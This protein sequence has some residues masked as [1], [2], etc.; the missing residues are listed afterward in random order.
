MKHRC[1][2]RVQRIPLTA[3]WSEAVNICLR[4]VTERSAMNCNV[5]NYL[6]H[7]ITKRLARQ[8][9]LVRPTSFPFY[10]IFILFDLAAHLLAKA[11]EGRET[12]G[13]CLSTAK[14]SND[15]TEI[16]ARSVGNCSKCWAPIAK[17]DLPR[18]HC[19]YSTREST[20]RSR[21]HPQKVVRRRAG[22]WHWDISVG[23]RFKYWWATLTDVSRSST[24]EALPTNCKFKCVRSSK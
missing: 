23:E 19:V 20:R 15:S 7:T 1:V 24:R 6:L 17:I 13:N 4:Q 11:V 14:S 2:G 21:E 12:D 9:C 8:I 18:A 10:L 16:P 22:E 5:I 3:L